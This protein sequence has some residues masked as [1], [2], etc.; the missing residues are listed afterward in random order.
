MRKEDQNDNSNKVSKRI[1]EIL[2]CGFRYAK[3]KLCLRKNRVKADPLTLTYDY[4]FERL[5]EEVKELEIALSNRK[6][7][8]S[9]EKIALECGDIINFASMI[10]EQTEQL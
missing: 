6:G 8:D 9:L 4:L 3:Y 7:I 1:N 2:E 10:C 5:K